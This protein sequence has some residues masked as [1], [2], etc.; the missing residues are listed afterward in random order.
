ME[1]EYPQHPKFSADSQLLW[2]WCLQW[3]SYLWSSTDREQV[4]GGSC[5]CMERCSA[6]LL[7]D[8]ETEH[9]SPLSQELQPTFIL[10]KAQAAF[11][12]QCCVYQML[13]SSGYFLLTM[14]Q[15]FKS[16]L[17]LRTKPTAKHFFTVLNSQRNKDLVTICEPCVHMYTHVCMHM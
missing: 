13:L 4:S 8:R 1:R 7:G 9:S 3:E 10:H 16:K 14:F 12:M 17:K 2:S 5:S 6:A 15:T 11:L